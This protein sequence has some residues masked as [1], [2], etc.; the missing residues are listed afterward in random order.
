MPL[1]GDRLAVIGTNRKLLIF[2][3]FDK[4]SPV[5]EMS[6]G[7]GVRLQKYKDARLSD[8]KSFD[9]SVGLTWTDSSGRN[10]TKS[11]VDVAEWI[12]ERAQAGR[13]APTGFPRNNRFG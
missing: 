12:G 9:S 11:M 2:N 5:P 8:L 7:K 6:R 10:F 3:P 13:V 4:N 1:V